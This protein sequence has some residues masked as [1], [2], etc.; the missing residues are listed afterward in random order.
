MKHRNLIAILITLAG[1]ILW[2]ASGVFGQYL[3]EN[4]G[5]TSGS[6]VPLRLTTA[7]ALLL[8]FDFFRYRKQTLAV[9]RSKRNCLDLA[10]FSLVG[11]S[12]CQFS[13]FFT[14][15]HSDAA[16]A[17]ILQYLS[18][19]F[20]IAYSA[21]VGKKAP[22]A[23][24][25]IALIFALVGVFLIVSEGDIRALRINP[26]ALVFGI[27]TALSVSVYNLQ[28]KRLMQSFSTNI[29]LGWGMLLGGIL[30]SIIMR[31]WQYRVRLDSTA[32]IALFAIIVGGS[33]LGFCFYMYGVKKLGAVYAS[34][35]AAIEPVAATVLSA[36]WLHTKFSFIELIGFLLIF[37]TI[38]IIAFFQLKEKRA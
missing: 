12:L 14:I 35:L 9:F 13:Y 23:F 33:I 34:M 3:F 19:V 28:P 5:F 2:G 38:F 17:T 25:I 20:I 10:V 22:R 15:E 29:I 6:L 8:I 1:G 26:L 24:E 7:G 21:L 4:N 16:V 36:V 37:S 18:P 32:I 27:I 30:L 31:P 11:V